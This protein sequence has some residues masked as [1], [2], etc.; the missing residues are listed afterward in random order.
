TRR[1]PFFE[2]KQPF[3]RPCAS[4][5]L[6]APYAKAVLPPIAKTAVPAK[7][8]SRTRFGRLACR[9]PLLIMN[10][11]PL[12]TAHGARRVSLSARLTFGPGRCLRIGVHRNVF[13][14]SDF[15]PRHG[16]GCRQVLDCRTG[17]ATRGL[18]APERLVH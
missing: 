18:D 2:L 5:P 13:E 3:M 12:P 11:P 10:T 1:L 4:I 9:L 16:A 15:Q 6:K 7:I 8:A 17:N 14:R